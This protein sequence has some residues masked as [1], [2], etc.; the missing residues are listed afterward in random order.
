MQFEGLT[1]PAAPLIIERGWGLA[2][3]D[4]TKLAADDANTFRNGVINAFSG[5]W[6]RS[7]RM[8]G[9]RSRAWAWGASRVLDYLETEPAVDAEARGR[10]RLLAD[11][12][13]RALGRGERRTVRRGDL[14]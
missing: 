4:R 12:K 2:V 6:R 3:L 13:D 10:R 14:E 9:K 11:G 8:L 7:R 1:D 5:R